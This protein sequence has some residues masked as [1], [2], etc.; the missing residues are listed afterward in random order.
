MDTRISFAVKTSAHNVVMLYIAPDSTTIQKTD[1]DF[2]EA[3][4]ECGETRQ[5]TQY[6]RPAM[7]RVVSACVAIDRDQKLRNSFFISIVASVPFPV[8]DCSNTAAK[9]EAR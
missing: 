3:L 1:M 4:W 7:P 8:L 6:M 5:D 9:P 2:F